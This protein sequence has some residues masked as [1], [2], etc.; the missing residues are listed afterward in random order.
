MNE[1][2]RVIKIIDDKTIVINIGENENIKEGDKFQIYEIG[3]EV[4]DPETKK[5]LGTLNTVKEVVS[6]VDVLPFM[7]ICRHIETSY[8]NPLTS[9][10]SPFATKQVDTEKH[11]NVETS[12]IT[13]GLST[14]MIIKIGD[15]VRLIKND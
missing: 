4:I 14:D 6:A 15:K 8:Y 13:G 11:L 2:Y 10:V 5:N 3:E 9:L 7:T 1:D 12:Q